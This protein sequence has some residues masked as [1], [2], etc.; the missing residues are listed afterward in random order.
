[1]PAKPPALSEVNALIAALRREF[2]AFV[3]NDKKNMQERAT[4]FS[5][6]EIQASDLAES[7][8]QIQSRLDRMERRDQPSRTWGRALYFWRY[9]CL[10]ISFIVSSKRFQNTCYKSVHIVRTSV[11]HAQTYGFPK[12]GNDHHARLVARGKS[13]TSSA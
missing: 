13:E 6:I 4:R 11:T 9:R 8:K 2:D 10:G 7:L 12:V 1:M 3:D 5:K